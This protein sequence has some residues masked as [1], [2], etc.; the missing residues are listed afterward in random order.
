MQAEVTEKSTIMPQAHFKKKV[1]KSFF[2][3]FTGSSFKTVSSILSGYFFALLLGPAVY[4]VWQTAR[5]FIS[6]S[7]FTSL[8]IPFVMRRD[9][10]FL[11]AEGRQK[12]A[13]NLA[14]VAMTYNFI[15]NPI[16]AV[17]IILTAWF[18]NSTTIFKISLI[19]VGVLYITQLFSGIGNILHKGYNDYKTLAIG[20]FIHGASL[21]LI[22]PFVYWKGYYALLF[23]YL[24]LSI[25]QSIY[26]YVKRPLPYRWNWNFPLLR[27]LVFTAFPLFLVTITSTVFTSIDRLLIAGLLDFTNV[28]LYSLSS[29]IA[30]PITLLVSSFSIVLFT[31]LNERYGKSKEPHVISK[32]VYFPQ[33]FFS[34]LL[35][36]LMGIGIVLLPVLTQ[37]FL[38]KY[39]DGVLAAQ[40]N[41]FAILFI[42]LASFSSNALFVLDKQKFIALSFFIAGC[43]KTAGS[44]I[45]LKIGYGI[46]GVAVCT[47]LAYLFYNSLMLYFV[48][49][50]LKGNLKNYFNI[51][52]IILFCPLVVLICCAVFFTYR[53]N[54]FQW[55]EI[56]NPW[57]QTFIATLI[58]I[59]VG[60]AFLYKSLILLKSTLKTA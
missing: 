38:P 45:A 20:D 21:L 37:I 35:P 19:I 3:M 8:G 5:V 26:F 10:I 7:T 50:S 23:G 58:F 30:Q 6:Y 15:V 39:Q 40:I 32:H 60:A 57:F 48:N 36:P 43:L 51:L 42:K 56:T 29:F 2:Q 13:E 18:L 4:G 55:M 11:R 31:Q 22:I 59:I 24:T 44:Y 1:I 54:I 17:G 33:K 49:Y 47:L 12:E 34:N 25:V 27:K 53:D 9:F 41:I 28:G 16:L 14:Q 52:S 46:G